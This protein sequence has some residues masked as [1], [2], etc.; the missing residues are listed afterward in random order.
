MPSPEHI[1]RDEFARPL[2]EGVRRAEAAILDEMAGKSDQEH[3]QEYADGFS[4]QLEKSGLERQVLNHKTAALDLNTKIAGADNHSQKVYSSLHGVIRA[5]DSFFSVISTQLDSPEAEPQIVISQMR[6]DATKARRPWVVG[7]LHEDEPLQ[8]GRKH[9]DDL[10]MST[11]R[12]H[13]T[14]QLKDGEL[15]VTDQSTNGTELYAQP[16]ESES[17]NS[18]AV[19]EGRFGMRSL[20]RRLRGRASEEDVSEPIEDSPLDSIYTWAPPSTDIKA[21]VTVDQHNRKNDA[22]LG[23]AAELES[24]HED[25][26]APLWQQF[27]QLASPEA[28]QALTQSLS[29]EL[30]TPTMRSIAEM[31]RGIDEVFQQYKSRDA[32]PE[33]HDWRLDKRDHEEMKRLEKEIIATHGQEAY[34]AYQ[35]IRHRLEATQRDEAAHLSAAESDKTLRTLFGQAENALSAETPHTF[36]PNDR[37]DFMRRRA[38]G[39]IR[40][41]LSHEQEP[42]DVPI[43]MFITAEGLQSW[44]NG[45]G[46]GEAKNGSTSREEIERYADLPAETAP[47]VDHANAYVLPDGRVYVSSENSHRV[48]AAVRRGDTHVKFRGSMGVYVLDSAPAVL[49]EHLTQ[50]DK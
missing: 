28:R 16:P 21:S 41:L 36:I 34:E 35:D 18:K 42:I 4:E 46:E 45:R 12:D 6:R 5:G 14:I 40:T 50:P 22:Q 24:M 39:E 2:P 31:Q 37:V 8:I 29:E 20:M 9:Q 3:A 30:A 44:D 26:A 32:H 17:V 49:G 48:A 19:D 38:R 11:S 25:E 10:D 15:S 43:G 47:P 7:V 13:C 33:S 27:D 23:E 1:P